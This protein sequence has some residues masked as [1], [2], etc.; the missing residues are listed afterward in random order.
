MKHP[1]VSIL[2]PFHKSK[3]TL[4]R[5]IQS[6]LNQLFSNFELILISNNAD[7]ESIKIATT[8]CKK[9]QRCTLIHE[10]QQG[11]VHAFNKG[12][13][14][15]IGKYIAR[16][17]ADDW[18]FPERLQQQLDF[19]ETHEDYS[20]VAGQAQYIP[21]KPDTKG[22][23]RYVNWSNEI[24]EFKDI[25]YKQFVESP[26]INPTAMWRKE[27]SDKYGSYAEG[28]FPEDY[29]LWL[30]WLQKGVKFHKLNQ[31]VIKW[32][33]S[34]SRLTRTDERYSDDAFFEVKSSYLANWLMNNNPFY[35]KVLVWGASK[36]SRR[37]ANLL[38]NH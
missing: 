3:D 29:E 7:D 35:P 2:L 28:A 12:L 15:S 36:I 31:L 20:V 11:V 1:Q 5:A 23:G 22:F 17:D 38:L 19:L 8:Y 37:R 9:D 26:V 33:D 32:Y 18:S 4:D 25:Y 16:M 30:R 10:K 13:S 34:D 27:V 14:L 24:L 6:I 21:H